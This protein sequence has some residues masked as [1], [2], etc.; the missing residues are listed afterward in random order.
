[1]PNDQ[2]LTLPQAAEIVGL[3]KEL[4]YYYVKSG[5][6]PKHEKFGGRFLFYADDL[7]GWEPLHKPLGAP[8]KAEKCP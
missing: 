7:R 6:G 5:R 4:F 8:K 3:P 2:P 1:M